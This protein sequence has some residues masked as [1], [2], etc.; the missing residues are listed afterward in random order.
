MLTHFDT[1]A[2]PFDFRSHAFPTKTK[3]LSFVK[4]HLAEWI[5]FCKLVSFGLSEAFGWRTFLISLFIRYFLACFH[6]H[7]SKTNEKEVNQYLWKI[8]IF[9]PLL[10]VVPAFVFVL[11]LFIITN[12]I[13]LRILIHNIQHK[14]E[15]SSGSDERHSINNLFKQPT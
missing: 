10:H 9:M 3:F 12:I 2:N 11:Y 1:R 5:S 15:E 4:L 8:Y 13:L 6:K 7:T 14:Y